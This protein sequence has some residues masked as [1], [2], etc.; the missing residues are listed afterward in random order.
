MLVK[1][2]HG[3]FDES[4]VKTFELKSHVFTW[5]NPDGSTSIDGTTM[6]KVILGNI[7]L[8]ISVDTEK[9]SA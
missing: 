1:Y 3:H 6:L 9:L 4:I 5:K 7:N 2:I 8:S